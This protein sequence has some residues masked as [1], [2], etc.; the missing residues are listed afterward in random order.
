MI[1]VLIYLFC[2]LSIGTAL[3]TCLSSKI[4][5]STFFFGITLFLIAFIFIVVGSNLLGRVID[6][7]GNP[8]DGAATL[9]SLTETWPINGKAVNPMTRKPINEILDVGIRAINS[10]V[11]VGRGQRLGI[12]AGS[13]VGKSMIWRVWAGNWVVGPENLD[14]PSKTVLDSTLKSP[15]WADFE[16]WS[17]SCGYSKR[18]LGYFLTF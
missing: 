9:D 16:P 2:L 3:T 11:T 10:L 12:I 8:I 15:D 14:S 6:A 17:F 18:C 5:R 4:I 1:E 7:F 13:G